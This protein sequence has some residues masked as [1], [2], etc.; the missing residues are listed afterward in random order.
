MDFPA[1]INLSLLFEVCDPT[2]IIIVFLH[3]FIHLCNII[4]SPLY[5]LINFFLK[6]LL[7]LPSNPQGFAWNIRGYVVIII[8]TYFKFWTQKESLAY[9]CTKFRSYRNFRS[10]FGC[11]L[12]R[13]VRKIDILRLHKMSILFRSEHK[14]TYRFF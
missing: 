8:Y 3:Q 12:H 1:I 11:K 10:A 7:T 6:L 9:N 4:F 2:L 13:D 14:V 5:L